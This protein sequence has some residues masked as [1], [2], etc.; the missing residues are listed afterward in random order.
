MHICRIRPLHPLDA[1]FM[2]KYAPF[3]GKVMDREKCLELATVL[4]V[5]FQITADM[6]DQAV[7][8][9]VR[10]G[11]L[12]EIQALQKASIVA[13]A[14]FAEIAFRCVQSPGS[15]PSDAATAMTLASPSTGL[16]L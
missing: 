14:A 2:M 6:S 8:Q 16:H 13:P 3:V 9:L 10:K 5:R 7:R 11:L 12:N 15:T 4:S 1:A